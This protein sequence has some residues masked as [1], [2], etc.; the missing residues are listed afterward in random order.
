MQSEARWEKDGRG[1][2]WTVIADLQ[3]QWNCES[4]TQNVL[5]GATHASAPVEYDPNII[6]ASDTVLEPY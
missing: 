4:S 2:N 3:A 6:D 1:S 5:A